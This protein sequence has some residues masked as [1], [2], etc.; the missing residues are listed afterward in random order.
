MDRQKILRFRMDPR[1]MLKLR[2]M[3]ESVIDDFLELLSQTTVKVILWIISMV[4]AF[5]AGLAF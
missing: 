1:I 4:A 2:I 3:V 5:A